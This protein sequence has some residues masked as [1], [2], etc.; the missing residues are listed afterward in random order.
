MMQIHLLLTIL[1]I[2][3][4]ALDLL[5]KSKIFLILTSNLLASILQLNIE[6]QIQICIGRSETEIPIVLCESLAVISFYQVRFFEVGRKY[7]S[8]ALSVLYS[9][10]LTSP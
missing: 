1:Y 8:I 9:L 2:R 10:E 5:R 4:Y 6:P 7:I 3:P